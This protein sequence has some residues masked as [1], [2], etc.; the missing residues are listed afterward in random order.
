MAYRE[1]N[2]FKL[3]DRVGVRFSCEIKLCV[4]DGG[5]CNGVTVN[6]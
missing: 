6:F 4:K 5:G 1:S 3:P 2:V